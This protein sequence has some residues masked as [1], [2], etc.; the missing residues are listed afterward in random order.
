MH[1]LSVN[2][3]CSAGAK[4]LVFGS[5]HPIEMCLCGILLCVPSITNDDCLWKGACPI[6][7]EETQECRVT[8]SIRFLPENA[9]GKR[10]MARGYEESQE[11]S[12][13]GKLG[14]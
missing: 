11:T 3:I 12:Q 7:F 10:R 8:G 9:S 1:Y 13:S 2:H 6:I 4:L 14:N 5:R